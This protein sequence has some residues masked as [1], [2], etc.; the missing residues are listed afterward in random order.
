MGESAS[1][2]KSFVIPKQLVWEANQR[3]K[4]SKGAPGV[5]EAS[6]GATEPDLKGNL[7]KIWNRMSSGTYF[8]PPVRAVEIPKPQGGVRVLGVPTVGDRIAQTVVAL[9][10]EPRT[11]AIFHPDS[12]GYR[13]GKSAHEALAACRERCWQKDWVLDLDIRAFFDSLDH[14]LVVKAVRANITT[15]QRWVLLYVQRWLQAPLHLPD[16]TLQQRGRGTPQGSRTRQC[17]RRAAQR[18]TPAGSPDRSSRHE[19]EGAER[20]A[21]RRWRREVRMSSLGLQLHPDKTRIVYCKDNRRRGSYEHVAF[22]FLGYTF[23][24]RKAKNRRGE[25]YYGFLP[26]VSLAALTRMNRQ[27]R[28][29]KMHHWVTS[30]LEQIAAE[31]N[32]VVRGMDELLRPVLSDPAAPLPRPHQHLP[33]ALGRAGIQATAVLQTLHGVVDRDPRSRTRPIR[34]LALGPR[35]QRSPMRRAE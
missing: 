21:A 29:W 26:A 24:P 30:T 23:Q 19:D 28:R 1:L 31:I 3:V 15:E 25:F 27:V 16:G 22:T 11:E 9:T 32:P 12:D 8:P 13:P 5:D 33:D 18:T 14:D 17:G 10:L 7:Y 6:I 35:L 34:A 4:V 20:A 2:E